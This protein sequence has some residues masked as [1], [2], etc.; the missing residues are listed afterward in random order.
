[1]PVVISPPPLPDPEPDVE[2]LV[3]ALRRFI[4]TTKC[5]EYLRVAAQQWIGEV[6]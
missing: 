4:T 2:A 3:E 6:A 5:P 1:M